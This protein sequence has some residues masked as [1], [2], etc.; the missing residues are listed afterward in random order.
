MDELSHRMGAETNACQTRAICRFESI[1]GAILSIMLF[2]LSISEMPLDANAAG[3]DT[4]RIKGY[5]AQSLLGNGT[6]VIVG[7]VDSGIDVNHP[8]LTG[9]VSGGQ[10]RLVAEA[11]FVPTEPTNTGDDVFGHGTAVAGQILS[12]DLAHGGVA[13]DARYI[14]ARVLDSNNSFSTD[15]WVINGT[16]YALAPRR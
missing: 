12:R 16:G 9:T 13:T 8:A 7:I 5:D 1:G 14:D 6:G 10:P 4:E 11:N 15:S 2:G 3:Q